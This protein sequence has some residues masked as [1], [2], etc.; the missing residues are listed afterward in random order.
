M[1]RIGIGGWTYEPWRGVFFPEGLPKA[2]E[3]IHASRR[4]TSIEVNGTFYNMFKPQ[5]F[6]KWFDEAP[7]DFVFS[8]KAPR[9][10]VISKERPFAPRCPFRLSSMAKLR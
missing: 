5:R 3:L 4:V 9:Y 6:R 2:R 1:I 8:L 7:D 10:A